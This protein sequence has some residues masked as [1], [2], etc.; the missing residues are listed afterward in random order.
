MW[1]LI[2][3]HRLPAIAGWHFLAPNDSN[4]ER[5]RVIS[6]VEVQHR[7]SVAELMRCAA[8]FNGFSAGF[9]RLSKLS[10]VVR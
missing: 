2:T 1:S 10:A 4:R 8:M 7:E 9:N 5:N 6:A 3:E